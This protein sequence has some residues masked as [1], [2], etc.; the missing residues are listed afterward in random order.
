MGLERLSLHWSLVKMRELQPFNLQTMWRT[1]EST[2]C[3]KIVIRLFNPPPALFIRRGSAKSSALESL[4]FNR[5]SVGN[6][7]H[8]LPPFKKAGRGATVM[9]RLSVL[10]RPL[11]LALRLFWDFA[12]AGRYSAAICFLAGS[13]LGR[14]AWIWAGRVSAQTVTTQF[15]AQRE[16]Q[17]V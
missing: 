3:L 7:E 10:D 1:G 17:R 13:M 4:S 14:Y 5:E 2:L 6:I 11:A 8:L 15:A 12:P 9:A 16:S